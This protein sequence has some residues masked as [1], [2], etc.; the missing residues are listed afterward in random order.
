MQAALCGV[1][2]MLGRVLVEVHFAGRM[3][4]G[5]CGRVFGC[6]LCFLVFLSHC[7]LVYDPD[8]LWRR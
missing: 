6:L 7:Y 8:A 5:D 4:V 2:K 1:W 3:L